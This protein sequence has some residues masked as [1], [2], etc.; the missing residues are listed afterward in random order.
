MHK[1]N[2]ILQK[3]DVSGS[4]SPKCIARSHSLRRANNKAQAAALNVMI[5]LLFIVYRLLAYVHPCLALRTL[6]WA[7]MQTGRSAGWWIC[8][9]YNAVSCFP[10]SPR[11]SGSDTGKEWVPEIYRAK[12]SAVLGPSEIAP[13][14]LGWASKSQVTWG[15]GFARQTVAIGVICATCCPVLGCGPGHIRGVC[16]KGLINEWTN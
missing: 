8:S 7:E 16:W 5:I 12:W 11:G 1:S 15:S 9:R 13:F 3:A 4:R 6:V 10:S 2:V 14:R